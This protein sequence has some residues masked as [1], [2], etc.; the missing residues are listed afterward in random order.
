V[1]SQRQIPAAGAVPYAKTPQ[2]PPI[3]KSAPEEEISLLLGTLQV[4]RGRST[5]VTQGG[6]GA[7]GSVGTPGPKH[8]PREH[9]Q[10]AR[11]SSE[12]NKQ[13]AAAAASQAASGSRARKP[14]SSSL[15]DVSPHQ[16]TA[17]EFFI[18]V[19]LQRHARK[20]LAQARLFDLG[21][22]AAQ[23][24]FHM[25]AWL[26][27]ESGRAARLDNPVVA[28]RKL[29][30]DFSWPFPVLLES[31]VSELNQGSRRRQSTSSSAA[32]GSHGHGSQPSTTL[33]AI[34][35]KFRTLKVSSDSNLT[36]A[37]AVSDSGYI[38]HANG[39]ASSARDDPDPNILSE[40]TINA[41]LRP[42]S[43]R[44]IRATSLFT[45]PF[46][47]A[48]L[49]FFCLFAED[50]SVV[51]DDVSSITSPDDVGHTISSAM[52]SAPQLTEYSTTSSAHEAVSRGPQKSEIQLRYLF[53]TKV[54]VVPHHENPVRTPATLFF[55]LCRYLL[56]I[57]LEAN[58]LELATVISLVLKDAL[59]LIRIVNAAR[60]SQDSKV[61]VMRL[62]KTLKCLEGWAQAD[63]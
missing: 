31:V 21:T 50:M 6:S 12:A 61:C 32:S 5:S 3:N 44:G 24:D 58:C 38:S 51:S 43:F 14:S 41:M 42:H 52:W 23:L 53:S 2:T 39:V 10:L 33:N 25:V 48:K 22:F 60:T 37:A 9:A 40:H 8:S 27:R 17:E 4:P 19:I 11:S 13:A 20:L 35:E 57:M 63:W 29:H 15:K 56:Q 55:A 1:A 54:S 45:D 16:Q 49:V 28:L 26:K 18:D 47:L 7:M 46:A 30:A 34:D 59:A 36:S 62:F